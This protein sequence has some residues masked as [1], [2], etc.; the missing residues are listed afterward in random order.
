MKLFY[1]PVI[2]G[3]YAEHAKR[4]MADVPDSYAY[5]TVERLGGQEAID[6]LNDI[7][8]VKLK[9]MNVMGN[10]IGYWTYQQ[11]EL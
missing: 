4:K 9:D 6:K 3:E 2:N 10:N 5:E 8:W 7:G 1:T 11:D